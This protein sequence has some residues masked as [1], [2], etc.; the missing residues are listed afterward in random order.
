MSA[1]KTNKAQAPSGKTE[2]EREF[3]KDI[4][5]ILRLSESDLEG[6]LA[7]IDYFL[8][9]NPH[10]AFQNALLAWKG[11]FYSEHGR[12]DDAIRE[13]RAA[14]ELRGI[15]D[16]QNFNTKHD[17]AKALDLGGHPEEAYSIILKAL[18]EIESASLLFDLLPALAWF[19][20]SLGQA[21][22]E[23]A[24]VA[25]RR[26]KVFYGIDDEG[27]LPDLISEIVRA[28]DL[29]REASE[30][31]GELE[32]A[33]RATENETKKLALIDAYVQDVKVP[34]YKRLAEDLG[35]RIAKG[36]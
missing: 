19:C 15:S 23:R 3:E 33:L 25:L 34:Y 18:N 30:R 36:E 10:P 7:G 32:R 9:R 27:A 16:L 20:S 2:L 11:L 29:K 24:E 6:A 26:G 13:L 21:P 8:E 5:R 31:Y 17:L 12:Y 28:T 35:E 4:V 1:M 22:P 14:E